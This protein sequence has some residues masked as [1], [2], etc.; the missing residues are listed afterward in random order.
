MTTLFL[1]GRLIFGLYWLNA[2]YNHLF[3]SA[4]MIGYTQSKGMSAGTAKLAVFGTGLLA[5]IGGASIILG[6]HPHYGMAC[7]VIF[8]LGVTWKMHSYWNDTDPMQKMSNRVQFQ[9]NIALLGATL[10]MFAI[11]QPWAFSI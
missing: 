2:A 5:L 4:G 1:I 6:Y 11:T 3:K 8:L 9:K 7:I 10:M